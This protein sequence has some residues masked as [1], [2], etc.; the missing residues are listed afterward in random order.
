MEWTASPVQGKTL[1][2][3]KEG[4]GDTAAFPR[5]VTKIYN[6]LH[7]NIFAHSL[8]TTFTSLFY[9]NTFQNAVWL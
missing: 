5:E 4:A 6:T 2:K 3:V 7:K 9:M 1:Y 8:S